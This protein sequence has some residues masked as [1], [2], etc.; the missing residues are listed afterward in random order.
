MPQYKYNESAAAYALKLPL[1]VVR[2][3]GDDLDEMWD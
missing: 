1:V 2:N 3:M